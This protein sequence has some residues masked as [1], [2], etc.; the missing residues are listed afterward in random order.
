MH[1]EVYRKLVFLISAYSTKS[2]IPQQCLAALCTLFF[3]TN[4]DA[5]TAIH[6][7]LKKYE[8]V[9]KSFINT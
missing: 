2:Q 9:N 1:F 4:S 7:Q 8:F 3:L 6:Q 5:H